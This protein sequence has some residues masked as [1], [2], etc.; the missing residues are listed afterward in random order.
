MRVPTLSPPA[1][2][3][4][5]LFAMVAVAFIIVTG[6]A[7]RLT[8]SGLGCPTWPTCDGGRV[9]APWQYHAMVEFVNR[10][11]T[12]LVSV[13]VMLAVLGSLVRTPRRRD[14][15]W[16]SAGLVVGV[17]AQI[18][19]GGLTVLFKLR[20][21]FV[22][23]HFLLSM[24]LLADAVV[25]HHRAGRPAGRTRLAVSRDLLALGRLEV[26]AAGLV[27]FLGTVVTS[28]G[29]HGGDEHAERLP[30]LL[31]DVARLHGIAVMLF[32]AV[33][34]V[35][36]WRLRR[37]GAPP[38][39]FRRGEILL[40]VLVAQAALGYVQYFTGVPAVLVGFHIAGAAAV[41]I[42]VLRF[43]LAFSVPVGGPETGAGG[44]LE[45]WSVALTSQ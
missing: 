11:I 32:L 22:M 29:P 17:L 38:E 7:V 42:A 34:L 26:A 23:A 35:A 13:L 43:H 18:V 2:R 28:S 20:P 5:T 12:G 44:T 19:L 6:G 3:R 14:L 45:P 16:L 8:G 24:V 25:L 39:L 37:D 31:T 9:V 36:L 15:V 10:T 1:Y 41:W 40:V 27:I 21:G 4:V 33:T 30:F